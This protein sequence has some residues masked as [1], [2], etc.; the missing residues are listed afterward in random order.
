M[1]S[2]NFVS[3]GTGFR[4]NIP[5]STAN[6]EKVISGRLYIPRRMSVTIDDTLV[7]TFIVENVTN[8]RV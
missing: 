5:T 6:F 1:A 7:N 2:N 8:Q 4:S 3:T